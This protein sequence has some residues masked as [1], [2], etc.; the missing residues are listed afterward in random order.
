MNFQLKKKVKFHHNSQQSLRHDA[1][2]NSQRSG[3]VMVQDSLRS[4][5]DEIF[6][7]QQ[8]KFK[9]NKNED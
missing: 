6:K 1:N 5:F 4:L 7:D 2:S 3:G 8:G 9:M